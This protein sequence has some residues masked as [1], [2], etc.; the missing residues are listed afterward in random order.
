VTRTLLGGAGA[1]EAPVSVTVK[2]APPIVKVPVRL[3]VDVFAAALKFTVPLPVPLAPAV[4][5]SQVAPVTVIQLHPVPAATLTLPVPPDAGKVCET[6]ERVIV[7]LAPACATVKACPPIVI[8]PERLVV[9]VL[10][11][12]L[13]LTVPLPEP[14]APA[15]TVSQ[16]ALL[17]AVHAQPVPAVTFVLPVPPVAATFAADDDSE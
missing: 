10:A 16:L 14:L 13:K 2:V 6:G 9:V 15:V 12:A 7:Q 5:V 1:V 17:V 4:M 8:V 3:L 11:A